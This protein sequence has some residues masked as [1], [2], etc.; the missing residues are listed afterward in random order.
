MSHIPQM[1]RKRKTLAVPDRL[2][3]EMV[4]SLVLTGA[5]STNL[6][7]RSRLS[8]NPPGMA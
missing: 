1:G 7:W 3:R 6:I 2:R 8:A 4:R 5:E